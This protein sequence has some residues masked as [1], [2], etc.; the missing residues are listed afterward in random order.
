MNRCCVWLCLLAIGCGSGASAVPMPP[1]SGPKVTE[2][3]AATTTFLHEVRAVAKEL[4]LNPTAIE[5]QLLADRIKKACDQVPEVPPPLNKNGELIANL[6]EI[7]KAAAW[8]AVV[9][10]TEE[11]TIQAGT[12]VSDRNSPKAA[13]VLRDLCVKIEKEIDSKP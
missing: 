1:A 10:K 2:F 13:N 12:Q 3:K 4:D 5:A 9:T 8:N 6:K 11:D 7:P